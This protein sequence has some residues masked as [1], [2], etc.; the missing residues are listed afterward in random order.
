MR[1]DTDFS[2]VD[3]DIN[4]FDFQTLEFTSLMT[5]PSCQQAKKILLKISWAQLQ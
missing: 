5:L 3:A 2:N 4:V 1:K